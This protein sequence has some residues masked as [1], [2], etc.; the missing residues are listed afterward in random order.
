MAPSPQVRLMISE[1]WRVAVGFANPRF[2]LGD[3]AVAQTENT[4]ASSAR[5]K[6]GR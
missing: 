6:L 1:L 4:A 5:A 2:I 3:Q